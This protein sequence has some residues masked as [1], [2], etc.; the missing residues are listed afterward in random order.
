[1]TKSDDRSDADL[2]RQSSR[3]ADAFGLFYDRHVEAVFQY[4]NRRTADRSLASDLTAETF[5]Q[6]YASRRRYRDKS[7]PATGWL[8]TIARR[9]LNEFFRQE[10]V[11]HTYRDR[12]GIPN[13]SSDDFDRVDDLDELAR[14][15]PKAAEAISKLS[16][17]SREALE[18]RVGH[19]WS[20]ERVAAHL[21]CTPAAARVRT[22]RALAT[23]IDASETHP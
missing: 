22:S 13:S 11:A 2:L 14:L 21:G 18:L 15:A 23:V 4:F 1:M 5:A 19:G 9:Q 12:L 6:A 16:E 8:F 10:R 3:S 20:Y 7:T 17:K